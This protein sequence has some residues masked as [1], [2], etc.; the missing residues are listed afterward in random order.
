MK[1]TIIDPNPEVE[2]TAVISS[3]ARAPRLLKIAKKAMAS[4]FS[5]THK[6]AN[7]TK[8]VGFVMCGGTV[9]QFNDACDTMI[10]K[11]AR[12]GNSNGVFIHAIAGEYRW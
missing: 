6:L 7:D 3:E 5:I 10:R 8:R 11:N 2:E 12:L 4:T 1:T 9:E